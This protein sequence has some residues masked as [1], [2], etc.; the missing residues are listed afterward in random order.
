M[1]D[2]SCLNDTSALSERE[3]RFV[4][5]ANVIVHL[6]TEHPTP[7]CWVLVALGVPRACGGHVGRALG[8]A[9]PRVCPE[10]TRSLLT[11]R[12][13]PCVTWGLG[14]APA[15]TEFLER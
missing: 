3:V 11:S 14:D 12:P 13:R 10:L 8:A 2:V 9:E 1:Y 7:G 6:L 15:F 5:F 4:T